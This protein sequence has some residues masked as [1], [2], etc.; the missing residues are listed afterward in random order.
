MLF[1]I[2][3]GGSFTVMSQTMSSIIR[4]LGYSRAASAG[5]MLGGIMNIILDPLFMFVILP[6]GMQVMGA[7][8]ATMLS[9][10]ISCS[11]FLFLYWRFSRRGIPLIRIRQMRPRKSSV[12]QIFSVGIPAALGVLLF[13]L[14]NIV[15][16]RL[17]AGH[18][19]IELAAIGIV[20]KAER[21]PLNT[22]VGLCLGMAP[23]IAYNY[24]AENYKRMQSVFNVAR[25]V[26][27]GFAIVCVVLYRGFAGEIMAAFIKDEGTVRYGTEFLKARCFATPLMFLCFSM[28]NF[29]Q[30]IGNGRVSFWLAVL[31][32]IVFN[33]PMLLVLDRLFGMSGIIWTQAVADF[34]TVVLSYVV[35]LRMKKGWMS[36]GR[37]DPLA[38]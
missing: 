2:V 31:R 35:Y 26:G 32:Q 6:D 37:G 4:C 34:C 19:D 17:S 21:L 27:V 9:N 28:V 15:I 18:G 25:A 14:T 23:L 24:A 12:S 20:L 13:D 22:G 7:A 33:I 36:A 8:I 11:F 5:L 1:V 30:A 10:M 29:M 3:I 16:Y 38:L